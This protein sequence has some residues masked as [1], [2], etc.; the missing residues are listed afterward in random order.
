MKNTY[1]LQVGRRGV[2]T[3]PK[4]LRDERRISEGEILQLIELTED[5]FVLSRRRS[6]VD[7]VAGELAEVWEEKGETLES[8]LAALRQRTGAAQC[9]SRCSARSAC[10][11]LSP[12]RKRYTITW[13][14]TMI[15]GGLRVS[16]CRWF[17]HPRNNPP[18]IPAAG[19]R[20]RAR[21]PC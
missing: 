19:A 11:D 21:P 17:R 12:V 14:S 18:S 7:E 4:A 5:V 1:S 6:R 20:S 3:L 8:M 2:I 15:T 9:G 13:V 16:P 10:P